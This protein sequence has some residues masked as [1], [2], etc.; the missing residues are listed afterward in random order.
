M[1]SSG[2]SAQK[3]RTTTIRSSGFSRARPGEER[4]ALDE[5]LERVTPRRIDRSIHRDEPDD[6]PTPETIATTV[7]QDPIEP[8][9]ELVSL[10]QGLERSPGDDQGV[11]DGVLGLMGVAKEKTGSR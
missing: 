9:I 8:G 11:L 5:R 6:V 10:T 4:V 7:D 3:R 2:R 1:A